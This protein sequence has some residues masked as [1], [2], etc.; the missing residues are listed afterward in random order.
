M[1]WRFYMDVIIALKHFCAM[2]AM[3]IFVTL[4]VLFEFQHFDFYLHLLYELSQE[5]ILMFVLSKTGYQFLF[6][7]NLEPKWS[8]GKV[9]ILWLQGY[10]FKTRFRGKTAF[11][12]DVECKYPLYAM[13]ESGSSR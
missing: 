2:S 12:F 9:S 6:Y 11:K 8:H 1:P 7:N 3:E 5:L 13:C 4:Q 10:R